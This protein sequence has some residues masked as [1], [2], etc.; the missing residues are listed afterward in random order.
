MVISFP[1]SRALTMGEYARGQST[2]WLFQS[3][4]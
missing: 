4:L 2:H 3:N 1:F